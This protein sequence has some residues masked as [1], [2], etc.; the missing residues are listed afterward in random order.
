MESKP[1]RTSHR[2]NA[3]GTDFDDDH[4]YQS[5]PSYAEAK[6]V[7]VSKLSSSESRAEAKMREIEYEQEQDFQADEEFEKMKIAPQVVVPT[8]A[9]GQTAKNFANGFRMYDNTIPK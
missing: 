7:V 6:D 9:F 4:N 5:K 3:K 2:S 8:V 1:H